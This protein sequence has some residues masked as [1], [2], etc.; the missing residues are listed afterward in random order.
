MLAKQ[1]LQLSP[2]LYNLTDIGFNQPDTGARIVHVHAPD[3]SHLTQADGLSCDEAATSV[4][5][6]QA[7]RSAGYVVNDS[8]KW[9]RG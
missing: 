8:K 7:A 9:A 6:S 3:M 2:S 1:R 5:N 4:A